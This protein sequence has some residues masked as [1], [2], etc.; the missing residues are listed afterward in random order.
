MHGLIFMLGG[1]FYRWKQVIAYEFTPSGFDG[2]YL[3][4][5]I[6]HIIKKAE[7]IDLRVHSITSDMG[8][9]NQAM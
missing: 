8:S 4:T 7:S 5:I 6:E 1:I 2:A 3:K 9:T